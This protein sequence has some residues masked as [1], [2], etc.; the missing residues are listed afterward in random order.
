VRP[1]QEDHDPAPP[2]AGSTRPDATG[3][4]GPADGSASD[5]ATDAPRSASDV[6]Q[7]AASDAATDAPRSDDVAAAP[8]APAA[9]LRPARQPRAPAG[10]RGAPAELSPAELAQRRKRRRL[11]SL[12]VGAGTA[13][14]V[15]IALAAAYTGGWFTDAGRF[16][17]APKPCSLISPELAAG[18]VPGG[19]FTETGDL[20]SVD[21]ATGPN[22][23]KLTLTSNAAHREGRVSGPDIASRYLDRVFVGVGNRETDLGDEAVSYEPPGS[24]TIIILMRVSNL[25]VTLTGSG[26]STAET[27]GA[28]ADQVRGVAREAAKRLGAR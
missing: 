13:L 28:P 19:A 16:E 12:L 2:Q 23:P 4:D 18:I 8:A 7:S 15:V 1:T 21:S 25:L 20:C 11:V 24:R 26:G 10:P 17:V 22:G 9:A 14:L 5:A 6:P 27:A 3:T